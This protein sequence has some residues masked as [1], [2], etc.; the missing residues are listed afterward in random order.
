MLVIA[1]PLTRL[2]S[3]Y[4]IINKSGKKELFKL[5]W[6]QTKLW[7]ESWYCNVVLKARQLGIST[8]VC[9]LYLDKCLYNPNVTAG[10]ICH[11]REDAE[12]MFKR[13]KFAYD[14][15]PEEFRSIISSTTDSAREL[16]FSNGSSI[17]VG[18]S[19]RS[20]TLQYLHI[21][22]FGKLCSHYPEKARE[23]ITGSL[24]TLS[25]GQ[26]VFIEST[27]EGQ[28]GRFYE[29]CKESQARGNKGLNKLDF[30]FHF[31]PWWGDPEYVMDQE[32][33]ITDQQQAYFDSLIKNQITL[34]SP[35]KW[36][37]C[38]K[39]RTQK[40]D[41]RR[42]FP[43]IPEEAF[44]TALEGAYYTRQMSRM[45]ID[46]RITRVR[47]DPEYPVCTAWDFGYSDFTCIIFF[48][49]IDRQVF[50]IDYLQMCREPLSWY[51]KVVNS[52]PWDYDK[53]FVPHDAA[54]HDYETG[55][56][57]SQAAHKHGI[58]F[59]K[60]DWDSLDN[61][62]NLVMENLDRVWIDEFRCVQLIKCLDEYKREWNDKIGGWSNKPLHNDAS[63]GA[64]A[65]RYLCMGLKL[66]SIK[67]P[68]E[69]FIKAMEL[70]H[71]PY[72]PK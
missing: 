66:L 63:H 15:L 30:K 21:S 52:K 17:R 8:F 35:Q 49:F 43:S 40:D 67:L 50:I 36:W 6:A 19:M 59:T 68:D 47:Y 9:L 56:S 38:A 71:R 24:N 41:M 46:N 33:P 29:L 42:E 26:F 70:K 69:S 14:N 55:N 34:T 5:N 60:I 7:N 2:Q 1:D 12:H 3:Q 22:E 32:V 64:D 39:S 48:Q 37:Y 44:Q 62:I 57:R 54:T 13:I 16:S 23:I 51:L 25:P 53:H 18:T 61:G 20:S 10:I 45:R 72:F 11:T 27:G 31:F 58:T 4:Y 28:E 65:M